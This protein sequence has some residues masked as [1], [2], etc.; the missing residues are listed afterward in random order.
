MGVIASGSPV[1]IRLATAPLAW[2][3]TV[4]ADGQPQSS[5]IW[6]HFDGDDLLVFSEP[7]AAKVRNLAEHPLVSFHLDGDGGGGGAVLTV[8]GR[9]EVLS[10]DP[11]P[12]RIQAYLAKY[13][14]SIRTGLNTTP[15]RLRAQ[16][17]TTILITPT[18]VRS[19]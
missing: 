9:A 6:F 15:E 10:G 14:E 16:F 3:T 8:E 11:D 5:Y 7:M 18:R 12:D 17:S 19:W 13:D 2:L 1:A 4:R